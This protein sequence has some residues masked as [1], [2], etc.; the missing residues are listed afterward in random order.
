MKVKVQVW[1]MA[2][3]KI[4]DEG[5]WSDE[6]MKCGCLTSLDLI[7]HVLINVLVFVCYIRW[8]LCLSRLVLKL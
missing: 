1:V 7:Y 6:V 2:W 4:I 3:V 5:W 8:F